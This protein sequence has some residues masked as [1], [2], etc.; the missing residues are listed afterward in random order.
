MISLPHGQFFNI[1]SNTGFVKIASCNLDDN[2]NTWKFIFDKNYS[3]KDDIHNWCYAYVVE[4]NTHLWVVKLGGTG[5]K[6]GMGSRCNSYQ[7][8]NSKYNAK[9]G[10]QNRRVYKLIRRVLKKEFKVTMY[11]YQCESVPV[12]TTAPWRETPIEGVAQAYKIYEMDLIKLFEE[13][14]EKRPL[15]NRYAN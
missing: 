11:A 12:I 14:Y 15:W 1:L 13:L 4:S 10:P 5:A 8:G 7:S 9:N 3:R 6:K 2:P